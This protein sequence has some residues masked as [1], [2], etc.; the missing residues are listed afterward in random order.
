MSLLT[1]K[2]QV[3]IPKNIRGILHLHPGDEVEFKPYKNTAILIKKKKE[4]F[5]HKWHGYL[6]NAQTDKTME[7]LR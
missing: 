4:I 1:Q 7:E 6:G 2:S 5:L 3:T